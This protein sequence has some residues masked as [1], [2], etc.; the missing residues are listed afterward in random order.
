VRTGT[1]GHETISRFG[2]TI[3][4]PPEKDETFRPFLV[5]C[6]TTLAGMVWLPD[7]VP[8]IGFSGF[9]EL[10]SFSWPTVAVSGAT[11]LVVGVL[12]AARAIFY[13][14]FERPSL[15]E[16]W[17][18]GTICGRCGHRFVRDSIETADS[19]GARHSE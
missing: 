7:L 9:S 5:V 19:N 4:P 15:M 6:G 11:G 14:V 2:E 1:S 13:N 18:R 16:E 12:F 8:H 17:A 3:A 10:S